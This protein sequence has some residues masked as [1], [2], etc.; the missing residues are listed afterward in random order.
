MS[1][2][3]VKTASDVPSMWRSTL[4]TIVS[5]FGLFSILALT[6]RIEQFETVDFAVPYKDVI[7]AAFVG[8]FGS[9]A[10]LGG[11]S[12]VFVIAQRRSSLGVARSLRIVSR[13]VGFGLIFSVVVSVFTDNPAAALTMGSF[14]GLVAGFASQTVMG[15]LV[16]GLFIAISRPLRIND[17]VTIGRDTGTVTSITY[18]HVVLDSPEKTTL[19]PSSK[20]VGA[21]LIKNKTS[22]GKA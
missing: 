4:L 1:E 11:A 22:E 19:I 8:L 16:A 2:R 10:V 20:V 18:M 14:A 5:V 3:T 12:M 9:V 15:N 21:V 13:L 6:D 7:R 17:N